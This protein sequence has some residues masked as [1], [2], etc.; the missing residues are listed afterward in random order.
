MFYIIIS[1]GKTSNVSAV[2]DLM[3]MGNYQPLVNDTLKISYSILGQ[4][5][6]LKTI[7]HQVEL[8]KGEQIFK[9]KLYY[10]IEDNVLSV[11]VEYT[12]QYAGFHYKFRSI[13]SREN[14]PHWSVIKG[15]DTNVMTTLMDPI[16]DSLIS[17][18]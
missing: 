12:E 4:D 3:Y 18:K 16:D 1:N 8:E 13:S 7:I 2:V 10:T 6:N 14:E 5:D 15:F 9:E 11:W 17:V